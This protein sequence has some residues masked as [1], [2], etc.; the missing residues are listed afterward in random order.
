MARKEMS[1]EEQIKHVAK[2]L[3]V[4]EAKVKKLIANG[5]LSAFFDKREKEV[6]FLRKQMPRYIRE[7]KRD[8]GGLN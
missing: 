7:T 2:Y 4:S 1:K 8:I 5:E 6:E 3:S